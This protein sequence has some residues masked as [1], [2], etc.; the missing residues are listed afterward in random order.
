M[1]ARPFERFT[2]QIGV[3]GVEILQQ[4]TLHRLLMRVFCD[5][6]LFHCV[7]VK[8][9][10][11]HTGR[12]CARGGIE[13][14]HLLGADTDFFEEKCKLHRLFESAARVRGHQIGHKILLLALFLSI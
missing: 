9:R 8:T 4:R 11:I 7:G 6:D 2:H 5:I 3:L 10:V 12:D 14:L 13:I 1:P